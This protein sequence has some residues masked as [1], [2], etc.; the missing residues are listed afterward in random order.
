MNTFNNL[1]KKIKK[2]DRQDRSAANLWRVAEPLIKRL[3]LGKNYFTPDQ[4]QTIVNYLYPYPEEEKIRYDCI[5]KGLCRL[6]GGYELERVAWLTEDRLFSITDLSKHTGIERTKLTRIL[7]NRKLP[8][9]VRGRKVLYDIDM[10]RR[11]LSTE[12]E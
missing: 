4:F 7:H 1:T 11:V 10:L 9:Q 5:A 12:I 6:G 2:N 8:A 3:Q